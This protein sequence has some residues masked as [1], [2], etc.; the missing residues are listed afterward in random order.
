MQKLASLDQTRRVAHA[1]DAAA[2]KQC[3]IQRVR[4]G[5]RAG[6]AHGSLRAQRGRTGFE[7]HERHALAQGLQGHAGKRGHIVQ[8]FDMQSDHTHPRVRQ[9]A[10][11][12][13]LHAV[14]RF[15]AHGNQVGQRQATGLHGQVQADIATLGDQCH[16]L[17]LALAAMLI[18]PQSHA[19]Q[20]IE[21]PVAIRAYQRHAARRLHQSSLQRDAIAP[22]LRKARGITNS[23]TGATRGQLAHHLDR[24]LTRHG[25]KAGIRRLG[26][27][28]HTGKAGEAVHLFACRVHWPNGAI[29]A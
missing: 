19:V 6:V 27:V 26:Q 21:H 24:G 4:P 20:V 25:H 15:V 8:A 28:L 18:G 3:V 2:G 22:D 29:K 12:Q 13:A 1:G 5:Q 16:A 14:S 23:P 9:Q 7:G 10:L 11:D 17:A